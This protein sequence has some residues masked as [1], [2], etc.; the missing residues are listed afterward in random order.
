MQMLLF[1]LGAHTH[2]LKMLQLPFDQ[3][4]VRR[5]EVQLRMLL[6]S[7]YR[8]LKSLALQFA[9]VQAELS[10]SLELFVSHTSAGLVAHDVTPTGTINAIV[11]DNREA[12]T[13]INIDTVRLFVHT[14]GHDKTPRH[15]RFLRMIIAPGNSVIR[16][17]QDLVVEALADCKDALLL[18]NDAKGQEERRQLIEKRDHEINKRGKL[19]YHTELIS[20]LVSICLGDNQVRLRLSLCLSPHDHLLLQPLRSLSP[21]HSPLAPHGGGLLTLLAYL[22]MVKAMVRDMISL[23]DLCAHMANKSLPRQL[24]SA[25][26]GLLDE[27]YVKITLLWPGSQE[28]IGET[29]PQLLDALTGA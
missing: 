3:R 25:Y 22:Q 18:F 23:A 26:I 15:L 24:H 20:L 7:C 5:D 19:V 13:K 10:K 8:F 9:A 6:T 12:C 28:D 16:A 21:T 27:A 17:N 29:L 2:A 1:R 11:Q 14:A 4:R